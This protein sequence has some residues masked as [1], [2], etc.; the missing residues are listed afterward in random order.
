MSIEIHEFS[1][2]I[3]AERTADGGWVSLGFTGQYMNRTLERIPEVVERSIANRE[4]AVTEGAATEQ[5]ALIGRVV[6]TGNDAWSV[7]AVVTRGRDEKGR[8]LSVYRYFL[9]EGENN[10]KLLI[11]GW[12]NQ[13]RPTFNPFDYRSVGQF[14]FFDGSFALPDVTQE[15]KNLPLHQPQPTL[16]PPEQRYELETIN[17]LAIRKYNLHHQIQPVAWAFNVEA[18]EQPHRFQVIQPA[19]DRAYQIL[20]RAIAHVPQVSVPVVVDEEALKSALR[21][22]MNS[23]QVKPEAVR[24]IAEAVEHKDITSKYWHSL[25]DGQGAAIAISQKIYSPQMVRLMTLRAMVIPETLPEFLGWLNVKGGKNKPDDNQT[26]SLEFQAAIRKDFPQNKLLEGLKF[27][28]PELLN[29]NITPEAVYC[30]I[31]SKGSAWFPVHKDFIV[32]ILKDLKLISDTIQSN[33]RARIEGSSFNFYLQVWQELI[34]Y[35]KTYYTQ[36]STKSY[37]KPLAELFLHLEEYVLAAYFY[38]VSYGLVPKNIFVTA[39]SEHRAMLFAPPVLGVKIKK[40]LSWFETLSYL[41]IDFLCRGYIVPIRTVIILSI[42]LFGS[43]LFLGFILPKSVSQSSSYRQHTTSNIKPSSSDKPI[44]EDD[45]IEEAIADEKFDKTKKALNT[46]VDTIFED[47]NKNNKKISKTQ[48]ITEIKNT[49]KLSELN[50]PINE[51]SNPQRRNLAKAIHKY[52]EDRVGSDSATAYI[53]IGNQTATSL[54]KD[55][56]KHFQLN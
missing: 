42:F 38:Q 47:S 44:K 1:T 3:R 50:Y 23:S 45:V 5:P 33:N 34:S 55:L 27:I 20:L 43:G 35:Y 21:S 15:A 52:Q 25:F 7:L 40:E 4:F 46:I 54:L 26:I 11:A 28:L 49:F 51:L 19:S 16:L 22:L 24:I 9:C 12:E 14:Y 56:R 53:E 36:K 48:V 17:A 41:L 32:E 39:F 29:Q 6:G 18:L 8:S 37:Y 13:R 10:L 31:K 30:L 2:G